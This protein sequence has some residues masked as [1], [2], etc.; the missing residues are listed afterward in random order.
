MNKWRERDICH[1]NLTTYLLKNIYN[2][3]KIYAIISTVFL[4]SPKKFQYISIFK[5]LTLPLHEAANIVV[6][7]ILTK[8][9]VFIYEDIKLTI[10]TYNINIL[11][12]T[13]I[14]SNIAPQK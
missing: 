7:I 14:T 1:K 12:K 10:C 2:L 3:C 9:T 13:P 6:A 4:G 11:S 5:L 8:A